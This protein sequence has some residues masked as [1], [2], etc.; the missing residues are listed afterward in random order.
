MEKPIEELGMYKASIPPAGWILYNGQS[1]LIPQN[2]LL[3]VLSRAIYGGDEN[4]ILTI[5]SVPGNTVQTNF[6]LNPFNA[7]TSVFRQE[8]Q[9]RPATLCTVDIRYVKYH[10][11]HVC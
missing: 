3:V 10:K 8:L 1:F 6:R 4:C 9:I 7:L 11:K 2:L 5:P